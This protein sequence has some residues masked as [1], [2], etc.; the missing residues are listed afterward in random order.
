MSG[1]IVIAAV[2]LNGDNKDLNSLS[3]LYACYCTFCPESVTV[4]LRGV[5]TL[6]KKNECIAHAYTTY[7]DDLL[8]DANG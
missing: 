6:Q 2:V 8:L 4:V 7:T 1:R 5:Q 3:Q